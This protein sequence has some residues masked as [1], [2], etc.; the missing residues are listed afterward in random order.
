M[1]DCWLKSLL[2]TEAVS[3]ERFDPS[4]TLDI[5]S[6]QRLLMWCVQVCYDER[7]LFH[8]KLSV[9]CLPCT[10]ILLVIHTT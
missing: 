1:N 5:G 2:V 6:K 4:I 7:C 9:N 8:Y 10:C 3:L